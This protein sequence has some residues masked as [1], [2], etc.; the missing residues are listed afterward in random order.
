MFFD[1]SPDKGLCAAGGGHVASGYMFVLPH[2]IPPTA[3]AQDSWRYCQQCSAMFYNGALTQGVCPFGSGHIAAGFDFILPHDIASTPTA[4]STWRF[5]GKCYAMYYDG[6]LDKGSCASGGGHQ[7]EGNNFVLS[8]DL[9]TTTDFDF[10]PLVFGHGVS[11][12]G[13]SHL[14]IREDGSYTFSGQ[15]HDSGA[16]AYNVSVVCTVED[17][18]NMVY[19]FQHSGYVYGALDSGSPQ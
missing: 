7:S 3:T 19:T 5:C 12:D 16:F 4:Q 8:H 9:P 18:Q 17:S 10:V 14:T 15:F 6:S 2:D 13:S 1:G 11:V